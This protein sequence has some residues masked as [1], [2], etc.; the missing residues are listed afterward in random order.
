[1]RFALICILLLLFVFAWAEKS[2]EEDFEE[3]FE[4]EEERGYTCRK[5]NGTGFSHYSTL[6]ECNDRCLGTCS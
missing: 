3:D 6:S 4:E 1:M 5:R 2:M